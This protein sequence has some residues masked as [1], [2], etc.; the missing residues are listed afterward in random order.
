M[1][2]HMKPQNSQHPTNCCPTLDTFK[3]VYSVISYRGCSQFFQ[4]KEVCE[5]VCSSPLKPYLHGDI[6]PGKLLKIEQASE[7]SSCKLGI[8]LCHIVRP[9]TQTNCL[10]IEHGLFSQASGTLQG[11]F[12]GMLMAFAYIFVDLLEGKG[13]SPC[14]FC[15]TRKVIHQLLFTWSWYCLARVL[16]YSLKP[17][18]KFLLCKKYTSPCKTGLRSTFP[19]RN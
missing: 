15:I 7:K 6:L 18:I 10:E 8:F 17:F 19:Q 11:H 12:S 16:M 3:K 9:L 1:E 5:S 2:F 4:K 14:V 13:E